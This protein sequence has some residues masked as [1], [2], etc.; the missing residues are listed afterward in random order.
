MRLSDEIAIRA[1]RE[2]VWTILTDL[3]LAPEYVPYLRRIERLDATSREA[4]TVGARVRMVLGPSAAQT[5]NI[6][7][8]VVALEAPERLRVR[9]A[10]DELGVGAEIE[11][12]LSEGVDGDGVSRT[13]FRQQVDLSFRS[14]FARLAAKAAVGRAER[15]LEDGLQRFKA[16]AERGDEDAPEAEVN[17]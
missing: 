6:E 15:E 10:H 3:S 7:G 13:D 11:W 8:E 14:M 16:L 2:R 1:T 4:I 9:G 5:V 12:R 17:A